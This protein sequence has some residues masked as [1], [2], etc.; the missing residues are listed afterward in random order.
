[1][2]TPI[3]KGPTGKM[4]GP[5]NFLEALKYMCTSGDMITKQGG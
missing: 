2:V 3:D 1:M 4:F 5:V